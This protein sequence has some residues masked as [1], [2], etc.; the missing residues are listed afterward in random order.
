MDGV[1]GKTPLGSLAEKH[2]PVIPSLG[3]PR[4]QWPNPDPGNP[5]PRGR[6]SGVKVV[7]SPISC[8]P[9]C[10]STPPLCVTHASSLLPK[11]CVAAQKT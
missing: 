7:D 1:N 11:W 8:S 6:E 3:V 2:L 5:D 9:N 4:Q 10:P